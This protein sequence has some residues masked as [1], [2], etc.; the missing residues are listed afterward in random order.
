M[1]IP[2]DPV[3]RHR[4]YLDLIEKCLVSRE[5]RKVD[6]SSLRSW[7]LFGNG[8]DDVP[9]LYNKI[10]PHI[11]QLTSFLYSAE[12]TRFSI[13]LG[14]AVPDQEQVNVPALTK[15]LHDEWLNSNADQVFSTAVTW[16]L[17]YYSN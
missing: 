12:T 15:A 9:A 13:N 17:A 14:A 3:D 5:Q 2:K 7:Y 16:A 8:P 11:D 6:Y 4:F 1:R 10:Y